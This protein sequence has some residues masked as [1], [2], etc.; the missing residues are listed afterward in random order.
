[1]R[2]SLTDIC[3]AFVPSTL[4]EL[5]KKEESIEILGGI[6]QGVEHKENIVTVLVKTTSRETNKLSQK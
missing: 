3:E 4:D 1:M 5:E 2:M 6:T